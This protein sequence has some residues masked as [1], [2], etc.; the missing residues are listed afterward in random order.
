MLSTKAV[1]VIA[2]IERPEMAHHDQNATG[3]HIET[4]GRLAVI[5]LADAR[6]KSTVE[7]K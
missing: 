6:S 3:D 2:Y 1:D 4:D 7:E 5:K